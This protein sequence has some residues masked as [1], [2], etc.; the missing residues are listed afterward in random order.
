MRPSA[1][2][3]TEGSQSSSVWERCRQVTTLFQQTRS[4][5]ILDGLAPRL[6]EPPG[7][8]G[9][10]LREP[11]LRML[12][13][14]LAAFNRGLCLITSRLPVTDVQQFAGQTCTNIFLGVLTKDEGSRM[15]T[16]AGLHGDP[17]LLDEIA[18]E[19]GC[20]PLTLNLL[21]NFIRIVY[22]GELTRWRGS[23]IAAARKG[24]V[25]TLLAA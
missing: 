8:S 23:A 18:T 4:L 3:E 12:V 17:A 19:A 22:R 24:R 2:S 1:S 11:A 16:T 20:H 5:L 10:T 7:S 6:Q 9:G 15:L 25:T 14:E 21:G 13:R